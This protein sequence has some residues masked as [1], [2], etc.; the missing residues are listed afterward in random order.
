MVLL[1]CALPVA[2][3]RAGASPGGAIGITSAAVL[4]AMINAPPTVRRWQLTG[5]YRMVTPRKTLTLEE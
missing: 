5:Q 1:G 4:F 2:L 3:L